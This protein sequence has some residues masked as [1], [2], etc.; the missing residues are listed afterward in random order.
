MTTPRL[1]SLCLSPSAGLL[2]A[3]QDRQLLTPLFGDVRESRTTPPSCDVLLIYGKI[4]DKGRF[5]GTELGLREIIRDSGAKIVVVASENPG[6]NY[7]VAGKRTGY[8]L[9][10]LVMT[11]DRKGN[12]LPTF[13]VR[14]F[15]AMQQGVP[16]PK[17][18]V[19]LAPQSARAPHANL[20]ETIFACELGDVA[21]PAASRAI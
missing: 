6:P 5:P 13:L 4:D 10:N 2:W 3:N 9:A 1:G 7:V 16:M 21:L 14:L 15:T 12:A 19:S 11:L 20:P 17:A 8:G 18:W